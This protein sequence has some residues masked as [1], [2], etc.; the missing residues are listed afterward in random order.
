MDEFKNEKNSF[1]D[2]SAELQEEIKYAE[3]F[4]LNEDIN[5]DSPA[6]KTWLKELCEWSQ[7]IAFAVVLALI[8]NQFLFAIVQVEGH[9]MDP[10]LGHKERLIV[11]KL[12]YKPEEKD[13]VIVKSSALKKYIVKRVI[14]LPGQVIDL[15][16]K[17]G[18][19]T[20]DGEILDEPYIKEKL[21][22]T[23]RAQNY[24][25]TV[26]E[27]TVFVMGDNRNNSQDSRSIGV[28]PFD[29]LV[30]KAVFRIMPFDRFGGLYKD[31]D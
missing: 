21:K 5:E 20:V 24:P 30:G 13:I 16:S 11:S 8:I 27:N 9:S 4:V 17:T 12:F 18:D 14:A 3:S 31:L 10:T 19:V 1:G 29:E 22:S 28:I 2:E 6:K 25:F 7:A 23:G 26:P 15:D